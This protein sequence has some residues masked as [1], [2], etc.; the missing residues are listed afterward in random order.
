METGYQNYQWDVIHYGSFPSVNPSV[1]AKTESSFKTIKDESA[2]SVACSQGKFEMVKQLVENG[3]DV[4]QKDFTGLTPIMRASSNGHK[5]IVEYLISKGAK[6]SYP[7]LC[8]IKTKIEVLEENAKAGYE[9]PYSVA[10]WKNFLDYLII[11]G[12]KQ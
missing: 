7:L 11:E 4:N 3:S 5:G 8:S 2:L 1:K 12:K 9:D 6:I 10:S